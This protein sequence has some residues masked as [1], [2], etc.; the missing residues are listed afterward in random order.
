M[1][2]HRLKPLLLA[3]IAWATPI[4]LSLSLATASCGHDG[5]EGS[6]CYPG[7][8]C[9]GENTLQ[10]CV[11]GETLMLDCTEVCGQ[12][13][14]ASLGC[15]FS[16]AEGYDLCA[17][18]DGGSA[19]PTGED[20]GGENDADGNVCSLLEEPCGIHGDCCHAD[21]GSVLCVSGACAERCTGDLECASDCC[22]PLEGGQS[23]CAPVELDLCQDSTCAPD[24][25]A[26]TEQGACCGYGQGESF[27]VDNGSGGHCQPVCVSDSECP[28]DCCAPLMSGELVCS[29]QE[30]CDGPDLCQSTGETCEVNGDCCDFDVGDAYCVNFDANN[31]RCAAA[32]LD[33]FE[34]VS[35]C[36]I[37]LDNGGGACAPASFCGG[38]LPEFDSWLTSQGD[39]DGSELRHR[40][41]AHTRSANRETTK[42]RPRR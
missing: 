34:C 1:Y 14:E 19:D 6:L 35:G 22:A 12:N 24:Y 11:D 16:E 21:Q 38:A 4:T 7:Q 13:N 32:C 2:H 41:S 25:D 5:D 23:A 10:R 28:T 40:R 8:E 3:A 15:R 30:Y 9:V 27:C 39:E 42:D 26:C 36:C 17:C 33:G 20:D 37:D 29:P 18:G 31:V